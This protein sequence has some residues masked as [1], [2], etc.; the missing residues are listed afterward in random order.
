MNVGPDSQS[1]DTDRPASQL[2]LSQQY[3]AIQRNPRSG[4]GSPRRHLLEFIAALRHSGV[5]I[6]MFRNRDRLRQWLDFPGH[7]ECLRCLVAAGGDGTVADVFN[8]YPGVPVAVLPSGTENLT[9]RYL[10]IPKCGKTAARVILEGRTHPFDLGLMGNQRFLLLASA[11]V[12]ASVVKLVHEARTGHISRASYFQ[13]L[14]QTLRTYAY[15]EIRVWVDDQPEPYMARQI[16]IVNLPIYAL[17]LNFAIGANASDGWLD[18]RLF[19]SGSAFQTARYLFKVLSGKHER[20]P[21]VVSLRARRV[22]LETDVSVPMQI[23][24]DPAGQTPAEINLIPSALT[25]YVPSGWK[26]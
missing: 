15:P 16:M 10:G 3:V 7:R 14:W 13:P 8:R 20:L 23:D 18:L 6:R 26:A 11:G 17:G 12:D 9:A 19:Q 4:A 1:A 22:R 21:D 25:L 5:K 24:G 2:P